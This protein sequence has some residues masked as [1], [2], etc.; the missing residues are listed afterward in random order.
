MVIWEFLDIEF[1]I[2]YIEIEKFLNKGV[3]V[4]IVWEIDDFI[5]FIFLREKKD[6]LYCMIL[7][8]KVL[9]KSIVYY[10]F[11]MDIFGLVIRL[12]CLNCFMVIIDFK[13]VYYFVFVLEKY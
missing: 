2:I 1:E 8:F 10:Y 5:F 4:R 9:N 11:K 7:N 13:D 3:I 12:I 6:G